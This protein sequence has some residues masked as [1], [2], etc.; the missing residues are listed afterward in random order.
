[1][2]L[3]L[4]NWQEFILRARGFP[5]PVLC[6]IAWN[7]AHFDDFSVKNKRCNVF[8]FFT[9]RSVQSYDRNTEL[10]AD[11]G[12][13]IFEDVPIFLYAPDGIYLTWKNLFWDGLFQENLTELNGITILAN[14][15]GSR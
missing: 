2:S 5:S 10:T 13:L 14:D 15:T 9:M 3:N 6:G 1:M 12:V 7:Q 11:N 8:N 4:T